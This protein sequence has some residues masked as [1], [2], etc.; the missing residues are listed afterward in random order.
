MICSPTI[1]NPRFARNRIGTVKVDRPLAFANAWLL[2]EDDPLAL[3]SDMAVANCCATL[4][5]LACWDACAD[6]KDEPTCGTNPRDCYVK[7]RVLLPEK[8]EFRHEF[9]P[10][11]DPWFSFLARFP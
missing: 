7:V 10:R 2:P 6:G 5:E 1:H 9:A 11:L 4:E 8:P 3:T